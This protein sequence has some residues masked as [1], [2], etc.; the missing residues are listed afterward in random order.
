MSTKPK[1]ADVSVQLVK[2]P[3]KNFAK[4]TKFYRETLGLSEE[5]AVEAYGWLNTKRA[6]AVVSLCC[7]HGWG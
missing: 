4:A 7:G 6:R 1:N 2:I 3:V 5:F